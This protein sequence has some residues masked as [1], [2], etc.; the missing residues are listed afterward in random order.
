MKQ[1]VCLSGLPRSGSTILSAILDQNPLIHAEGNSAVCQFIWDLHQTGTV[2]AA[3]QLKGN[4]R[5]GTVK[6]IIQHIPQI[7]YKDIPAGKEIVVDKCRAWTIA[8]NVDLLRNYID[9][10]IKII[11]LERSVTAI[12]QSFMKLYQKNNWSEAYM[13]E[14]LKAILV[15]NTEP[16]MRSIIGIN[17]ARKANALQAENKTFLFVNYDDLIA[18]PAETIERIY[19]FCGWT[20]YAHQFENIV[21]AHPE[22]DEFYNLKGFHAIRSAL[23]K[24]PNTVVLPPDILVKCRKIDALMWGVP[25]LAPQADAKGGCVG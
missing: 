3:E 20:P 14:V 21:N 9:P 1:F 4:N 12:M 10:A 2:N 24:E 25:P 17:M 15:P 13:H 7:Y 11:V 22:N 16:V 18:N 19:A 23:H 6:D 5:M 8:A